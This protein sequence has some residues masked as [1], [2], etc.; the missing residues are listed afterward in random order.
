MVTLS[1]II[2]NTLIEERIAS[3]I[4]AIIKEKG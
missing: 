2:G 1:L 3:S 4:I